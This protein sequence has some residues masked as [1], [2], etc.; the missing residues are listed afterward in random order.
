MLV[1]QLQKATVLQSAQTVHERWFQHTFGDSIADAIAEFTMPS[2]IHNLKLA[3]EPLRSLAKTIAKHVRGNMELQ[4][5]DVSP[6]LASIKSSVITM[7]GLHSEEVI[8]VQSFSS[9]LTVL[10]T[11]T[12]PKKIIIVGSDGKE[13]PYLLKGKEDLHLDERVMQFNR[14]ANRMLASSANT[15]SRG[16]AARHYSV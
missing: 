3:S 14:V 6:T 5:A 2:D 15:A 11:K 1:C 4:L 10:A 9:A 13:Y 16:L 8:T 12:K 7:P